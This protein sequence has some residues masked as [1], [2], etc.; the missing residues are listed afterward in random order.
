MANDKRADGQTTPG[1]PSASAAMPGRVP[2]EETYDIR[3]ARDGTWYHNGDP[4]RRIELAK[5]FS[6][7]LQRDEAGDYWLITPAERGRIAVEDAPFV[8][9]EMT[10][11]GSGADQVLS[12]RTNLD[13]RVEAGPDH[14]IRVAVNP[15]TGEPA[16]Y[17]EI[18]GRLEARILRPV[19]Y[20]MV[21]RSETRRTET[22]ESEVGLWS[23][24]VFFVL[25]RLP[26]D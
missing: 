16:P 26:G 25:G 24:K 15:E 20:D 17:I 12:F 4:I 9:V 5:L 8:A 10:A 23:N 1:I 2:T 18:R 22:G 14:P 13:Q 19:F 21:E 3:I 6:T 7:V 11:A